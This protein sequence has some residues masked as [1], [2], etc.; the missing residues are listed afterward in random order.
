M[1]HIKLIPGKSI[2]LTKNGYP[3]EAYKYISNI[4]SEIPILYF[5]H[6]VKQSH[7]YVLKNKQL[8]EPAFNVEENKIL[9]KQ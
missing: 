7:E 1:K 3:K 4:K 2:A 9:M 5:Q 8:N 6:I